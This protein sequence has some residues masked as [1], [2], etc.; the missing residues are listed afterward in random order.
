MGY[1]KVIFDILK[2]LTIWGLNRLYDVIDRNN[3]GD[4]SRDE[5][6]DF[7]NEVREKASRLINK[8]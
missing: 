6:V 3:D 2:V 8:A 5:I 4:I 7:F 1:K